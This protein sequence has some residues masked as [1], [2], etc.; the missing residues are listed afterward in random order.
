[1]TLADAAQAVVTATRD[2]DL[3]RTFVES[4]RENLAIAEKEY[5]AALQALQ[6]A[7]QRLIKFVYGDPRPPGRVV[8][9][10]PVDLPPVVDA[11]PAK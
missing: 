3:K 5:A 6:Q 4:A 11:E 9:P 2:E 7:E 10:K 8:D 1:M